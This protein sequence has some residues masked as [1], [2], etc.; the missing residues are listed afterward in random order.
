MKM[1]RLLTY[2]ISTLLVLNASVCPLFAKA[3]ITPKI[4]FTSARNGNR[5]VYIMNPDGSEQINLTRHRADDQ[6]AVWSP[7]G[8]QILFIS[9][10]SGI[11]DLYLMDPD[12]SNVRRFFKRKTKIYRGSPTWSPDGKHIAYAAEE[13]GPY[14]QYP[15]LSP[16]GDELLYTREIK[17]R[18]QIFKLDMNSGVR[19]QL[20]HI[21]CLLQ[22]NAGGDW[23][24]PAYALPVSPQRELLTTPWGE[25]K[26]K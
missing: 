7:I 26:K 1:T 18:F 11:R 13:N 20:T 23:F 9:D 10:R 16:S 4:L 3:P 12:G 5:D 6:Q 21:G 8:E 24:D 22:A 2:A 19:T 17:G 15:K 14:A 25:I